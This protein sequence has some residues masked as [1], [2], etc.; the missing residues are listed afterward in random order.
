MP[1]FCGP[2][3]V[4]FVPYKFANNSRVLSGGAHNPAMQIKVGASSASRSVSGNPA[5]KAEHIQ[6]QIQYIK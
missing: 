3:M 4:G 6:L 1:V 5:I 2:V